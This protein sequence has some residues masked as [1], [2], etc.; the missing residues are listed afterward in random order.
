MGVERKNSSEGGVARDGDETGIVGDAVGPLDKMIV[1]HGHR[2]E[3][4]PTHIGM[5]AAAD[6][7]AGS[8]VVA[9][10]SECELDGVELGDQGDIACDGERTGIVG[11]AIAPLYKIETIERRCRQRCLGIVE[12]NPTT[13]DVA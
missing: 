3:G 6:D 11:I 7:I 8:I 4:D 2:S 12:I 9:S 10:G 1:G 13:S 5:W